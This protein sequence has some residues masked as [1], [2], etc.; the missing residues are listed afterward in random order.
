MC[1][2]LSY[3]TTAPAVLTIRLKEFNV[4]AAASGMSEAERGVF[5]TLAVIACVRIHFFIVDLFLKVQTIFV[6]Q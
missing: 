3:F 1:K 6:N 2:S 5:G 4:I